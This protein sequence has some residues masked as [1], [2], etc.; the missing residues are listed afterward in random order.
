M[1][2]KITRIKWA[3]IASL[4]LFFSA[5]FSKSAMAETLCSS[6]VSNGYATHS[7]VFQVEN[8][9]T[10]PI[11]LKSLS[12]Q[13]S[14]S[15]VY[16]YK[17]LYNTEAIMS[18]GSVW[19]SGVVGEGVGGWEAAKYASAVSVS[20]SVAMKVLDEIGLV[21]PAGEVYTLCLTSDAPNI[22]Y[23]N[24]DEEAGVFEYTNGK[25]F[26][27]R[28]GENIG[29]SGASAIFAS[30]IPDAHNS[31]FV[32]CLEIQNVCASP[33]SF[34]AYDVTANSAQLSWAEPASLPEYG[35]KIYVTTTSAVPDLLID[36]PV[37]VVSSGTTNFSVTGLV[38][39]TQYYAWIVSECAS[40]IYGEFASPV[41]FTTDLMCSNIDS[42]FISNISHTGARISYSSGA[43]AETEAFEYYISTSPSP[44]GSASIATGIST[45]TYV[46]ISGLDYATTYFVWIRMICMPGK[47][48]SWIPLKS[49]ETLAN[50]GD[51]TGAFPVVLSYSRAAVLWYSLTPVPSSGYEYYYSTDSIRPFSYTFPSGSTTGTNVVL[52]GLEDNTQYY[53]WV[54]S[55]CGVDGGSGLW[56]A[57]PVKF[58]TP[59]MNDDAYGAIE[60]A[61]GAGCTSVYSNEAGT[62]STNEPSP[63]CV[64]DFDY[65]TVWFKF[66]APNS[67]N[68]KISNDYS[69]SR[70]AIGN[71]ELGLYDV[72]DVDDYN[73][74]TIVSCDDD[75]G[76]DVPGKSIMYGV[77]LTPGKVYY[78]AVSSKTID[79]KG[80]FCI[81]VEEVTINN[82]SKKTDC[83][84]S[85][86]L[87]E[88]KGSYVG[89]LSLVDFNGDL[90]AMVRPNLACDCGCHELEALLYNEQG[91]VRR[92]SLSVPY[93]DRNWT[94]RSTGVEVSNADIRFYFTQ[95]ELDDLGVAPE[96]LGVTNYSPS[97]ECLEAYPSVIP[98]EFLFQTGNGNVVGNAHWVEV[99][100]SK[101]STFFMHEGLGP[102]GVKLDKLSVEN[103]NEVNVLKWNS[104]SERPEIGLMYV[105][106][107]STDGRVYESIGEEKAKG[108]ASS[109]TYVDALP[110]SG[111]NYYRVRGIDELGKVI[112]TNIVIVEV[113]SSK[114]MSVYPN[115]T[116]GK[117][118]VRLNASN[119]YAKIV[120]SDMKGRE[121]LKRF[122]EKGTKVVELDLSDFASGIYTI[123]YSD[124]EGNHSL[125]INKN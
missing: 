68:V 100:V 17:L 47:L 2:S 46:D 107:R 76:V 122:V 53:F 3:I 11:V 41:T 61:L 104:L 69:V 105:I 40:G 108:V 57:T 80:Q 115:P 106:E 125:N 26:V 90:I 70:N 63:S 60:L 13:S 21:I 82:L 64:G 30:M 85:K 50:C 7:I 94:L 15:G 96:V 91:D 102:L 124:E 44:P 103:K 83:D 87:L 51:V 81:T 14:M 84:A 86:K 95:E 31:G 35:Y 111:I 28:T 43:M 99:N 79:E 6:M 56:S 58:K 19:T 89:W 78:I 97:T 92:D 9:N 59:L 74:F 20:G 48:S 112:Y 22:A 12:S 93:L 119:G 98:S 18:S 110:Q 71:T 55:N 101:F 120:V 66:V 23:R 67:G 54:R 37:G 118:T 73:T 117:V 45:D 10:F 114:K 16:Q 52:E 4:A 34:G 62:I 27:I 49:F 42:A 121:V 24:L 88:I 1:H 39:E 25:G 32:G 116:N 77:D 33:N 65:G 109:Y 29:F 36:T 72:V 75:N 5:T 113:D 8:T 123:Q 38:P